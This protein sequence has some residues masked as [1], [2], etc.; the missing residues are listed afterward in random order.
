MDL[1]VMPTHAH[2][3]FRRMLMGSITAKVVHDAE[4]AVWTGLHLEEALVP[5]PLQFR[6][7]ACTV[8]LFPQ[9]ASTQKW[10]ALRWAAGFAS[11]VKARLAIIHTMPHVDD[12][13]WRD[14]M[15]EFAQ[16]EIAAEQQLLKSDAEVHLEFGNRANVVVDRAAQLR[17]DLLVMERGYAAP[18]GKSM[19]A[20]G[21]TLLRQS[22]C[23][24]V[25]VGTVE[26][27]AD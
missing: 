6:T 13:A 8:D 4:C 14:R 2:G 3:T 24:V 15:I 20:L 21:Y 11:V 16:S 12:P 22:P 10:T 17:A 1:I 9:A 7:V 25:S 23:P 27:Y 19:P 18:G 26:S 5:D